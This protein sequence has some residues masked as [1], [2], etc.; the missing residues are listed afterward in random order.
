MALAQEMQKRLEAAFQPKTLEIRDD[1]ESHRGH[2][3]FREG[4]ESHWHVAI[5]ADA[6]APMSRIERHRAIH[7]ALGEDIISRI[8]ALQIKISD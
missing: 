8:H 3:G 1:S 2:S 5:A 6:F 4:G 7:K